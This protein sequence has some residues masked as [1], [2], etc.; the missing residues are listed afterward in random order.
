MAKKQPVAPIATA[1]KEDRP[2]SPS[3]VPIGEK[4]TSSFIRSSSLDELDDEKETSSGDLGVSPTATVPSGNSYEETMGGPDAVLPSFGAPV[5]KGTRTSSISPSSEGLLASALRR[6][7]DAA[8]GEPAKAANTEGE[9]EALAQ[10]IKETE[11]DLSMSTFTTLGTLGNSLAL[12]VLNLKGSTMGSEGLRGLA[13]VKTLSSI[14]VSHMKQLTSLGPM[15]TPTKGGHCMIQEIDAQCS[16]LTDSGLNGLEQLPNLKKLD[17]SMTPV[18]DVR[19]LAKSR[20]L[21]ELVLTATK[22]DSIGI[23]GLENIPTLKVLNLGRTKVTSL[24]GLV[25]STS[26]ETLILYSCKITDA[27][28]RGI[29]NMPRLQTLDVSTTKITDLSIFRVSTSLKSIKA[30]WLALKNCTTFIQERRGRLADVALD[31]SMA[32]GDM[33]AGYA[34]LGEIPT[35]ETVDLS[36]N[37]IRSM[38]SL[39]KSKSIKHLTLYRTRLENDG[40]RSLR[41]LAPT[42]ETLIIT[43]IQTG[44]GFDEEDE[45]ETQSSLLSDVSDVAALQKLVRL[46]LSFT[47]VFDLRMLQVLKHLEELNLVETLVTDDGL[48]GIEKIPSLRVLDLSQTS[49]VSLQFLSAGAPAL[50]RIIVRSSRNTRGFRL[51]RLE[52]LPSLI[53]LD[54]SDTVVEDIKDMWKPAWQLKELIWRWKERREATGPVPALECWVTSERLTGIAKL[55]K[56][57]TLD[58]SNSSVLKLTFLEGAK[59][60]QTVILNGCRLL[61]DETLQSIAKLS[62]LEELDLSNS[63]H[64]CDVSPL[65]ACRQLRVLRLTYTGVTQE[66]LQ[67]VSELPNLKTLEILNT[68]AEEALV[69]DTKKKSERSHSKRK[70]SKGGDSGDLGGSK[71]LE[72]SGLMGSSAAPAGFRKPRR[73]RVSFVSEAEFTEV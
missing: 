4:R 38:H 69:K 62:A 42:L 63:P 51:G 28:V 8:A 64:I 23:Q 30:Q 57:T 14:C 40:I 56:L 19:C 7:S 10:Y 46:D 6:T 12:R 18:C 47:D 43:N 32:W 73:R 61:R 66:T 39:C 72:A 71:L 41:K 15:I 70:R 59:A 27:D 21:T 13:D 58:I 67:S 1:A 68:K 33:E 9:E 36:F 22:V 50:E 17:L 5:A 20:S 65:A 52:R 48:R 53:S 3:P 25:K 31:S 54:I 24:S 37:T 49:V 45:G 44:D 35:L 16:P 29:E 60:L 11:L 34:G 2:P 26:I 55:P